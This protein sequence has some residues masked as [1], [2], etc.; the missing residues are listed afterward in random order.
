MKFSLGTHIKYGLYKYCTSKILKA[1][2]GIQFVLG[3]WYFIVDN[4]I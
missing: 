3:M 2:N 4:H 1:I